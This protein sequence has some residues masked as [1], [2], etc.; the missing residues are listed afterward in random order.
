[1]ASEMISAVAGKKNFERNVAL[2]FMKNKE[3][4][5]RDKGLRHFLK[6]LDKYVVGIYDAYTLEDKIYSEA[7]TNPCVNSSSTARSQQ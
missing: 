1:M 6:D 5:L 7:I 3:Q 2:K 4:Y